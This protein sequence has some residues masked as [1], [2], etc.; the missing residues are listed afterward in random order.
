VSIE[1]GWGA[2]GVVFLASFGTAV[3]VIVLFALGISV[4]ATQ[5]AGP[6]GAPARPP[7]AWPVSM[8]CFLACG[9]VVAYGLYL[10]IVK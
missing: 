10:I 2:L 8:I 6:A 5:A 7:W 3:G 9:L 1:I 4:L